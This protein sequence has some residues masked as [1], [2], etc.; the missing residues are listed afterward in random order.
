MVY[1]AVVMDTLWFSRNQK[2][3]NLTPADPNLIIQ[4][5]Q[6][7]RRQHLAAWG[8]KAKQDLKIWSPPPDGFVKINTD[9]AIR[10]SYLAIVCICCNHQCIALW[11][12]SENFSSA[13]TSYGGTLGYPHGSRP[14]GVWKWL[15]RNLSYWYRGHYNKSWH[16]VMK[17]LVTSFR[18]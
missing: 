5:I 14:S 3:H 17:F 15:S 7:C 9:A 1:V 12:W 11:A 2:V 6:R 16:L 10:S 8:E 13:V 18:H 4:R